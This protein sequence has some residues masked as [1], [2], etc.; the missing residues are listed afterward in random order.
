MTGDEIGLLVAAARTQLADLS[1][2]RDYRGKYLRV[3]SALTHAV[4]ALALS[5]DRF[6]TAITPKENP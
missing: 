2:T 3:G 4:C 5:I 1:G 6:A